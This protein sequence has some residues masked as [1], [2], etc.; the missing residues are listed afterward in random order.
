M[1]PCTQKHTYP[2]HAPM[3]PDALS[4]QQACEAPRGVQG[5]VQQLLVD[6]Q[7]WVPVDTLLGIRHTR[8]PHMLLL[9]LAGSHTQHPTQPH[10]PPSPKAPLS[11]TRAA[12]D[13][14]LAGD[15]YSCLFAQMDLETEQVQLRRHA[16]ARSI[17]DRATGKRRRRLF[18]RLIPAIPGLVGMH[19]EL[20]CV[21]LQISIPICNGSYIQHP[22]HPHPTPNT[23][24]PGSIA[25]CN[26]RLR[27]LMRNG[28][29]QDTSIR[30]YTTGCR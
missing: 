1:H 15:R 24:T 9:G 3:H 13:Q 7:L 28:Q 21:G 12:T 30:R 4:R 22:I 25:M 27:C 14:P 11:W 16:R 8:H 29:A 18:V 19:T 26:G 20:L 23:A 17:Q 5:R 2:T 10:P 6:T